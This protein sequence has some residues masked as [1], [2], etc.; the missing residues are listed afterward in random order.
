[1]ETAFMFSALNPQELSVVVDAMQI[2]K[3]KAGE[4]IIKQG[5]DGDNLYLVD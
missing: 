3:K 1:M 5:E 4:T 2:I